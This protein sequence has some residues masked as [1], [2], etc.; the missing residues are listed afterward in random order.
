M[1]RFVLFALAAALHSTGSAQFGGFDRVLSID[2]GLNAPFQMPMAFTTHLH[3]GGAVAGDIDGDGDLDL[4]V[5]RGMNSPRLFINDGSGHF[6]DGT[7]AAGLAGI[8]GMPNGVVL[9]DV[10]GNG[11]LDLLVGGIAGDRTNPDSYTPVRVFANDGQGD[12]T[13]ATAHSNLETT[14]DSHSMALADFDRDG[15]LDLFVTYWQYQTSS[16]SGHLWE[17]QGGGRFVDV[18]VEAGIGQWYDEQDALYNFTPTFTDLD[19]DGWPDLV[20]AADFGHSRV[21]RNQGDGTFADATDQDVITDEN[22]MG[23]AVGDF[24]NDGDFDWF[25]TA[26]W[27]DSNSH[28]YGNSGNRLYRNDGSGT[29]DDATDEAGVRNGSW[30]WGACSADFDN[31]GWLDLFMVNGYQTHIP[32][33]LG[34]PARLFMNDG[35]GSFTDRAED[36]DVATTGQ[37]RAV[38]CFDSD[39]DGDIDILVQNS[40]ALGETAVQPQLYRNGG[41]DNHWL[42]VRL[43][44]PDRNR[45]GIGARIELEAGELEQVR[46]VRAGGSFLSSQVPEAHFGLG[47]DPV[48][49]RLTVHWPNGRTSVIEQIKGDRILEIAY[50]DLFTSRFQ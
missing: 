45:Q 3:A 2:S 36:F 16:A 31:D 22:G 20:I 7:A 41:T 15:D 38:V 25:V 32:R 19:G 9:A 13:D 26:I 24:D 18:S 40:H 1:G 39:S 34:Q 6:S 37:G 23:A 49:D 27:S 47:A 4:V 14:L 50:D 5:M 46:E 42:R 11:A 12:F 8:D 10:T 44:G 29:F 30:G 21:F 28:E 35:D 33:F 48:V 43:V 17:N